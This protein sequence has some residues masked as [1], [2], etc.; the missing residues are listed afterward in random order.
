MTAADGVVVWFYKNQERRNY[1]IDL[2]PIHW[3]KDFEYDGLLFFAHMIFFPSSRI[4]DIIKQNHLFRK[5]ITNGEY[6]L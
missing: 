5:I 6:K 2:K 1:L 3:N 4:S